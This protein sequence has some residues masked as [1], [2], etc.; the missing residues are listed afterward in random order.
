MS[1]HEKEQ[2]K[3]LQTA[4]NQIII[5]FVGAIIIGLWMNFKFMNSIEMTMKHTNENVNLKFMAVDKQFERVE[6]RID[7]V[8]DKTDEIRRATVPPNMQVEQDRKKEPRF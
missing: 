8:E 6:K 1:E 2:V 7:K 5:V 3:L 4:K